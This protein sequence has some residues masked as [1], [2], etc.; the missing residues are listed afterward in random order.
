MRFVPGE[1]YDPATVAKVRASIRFMDALGHYH[2]VRQK[3]GRE[4]LI[5]VLREAGQRAIEKP[6]SQPYRVLRKM[7]APRGINETRLPH[8]MVTK[9]ETADWVAQDWSRTAL[10]PKVAACLA[11]LERD[12]GRPA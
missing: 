2:R 7:A 4:G 11:W 1:D 8:E 6:P 9:E 3:R 12:F 10:K 5:L